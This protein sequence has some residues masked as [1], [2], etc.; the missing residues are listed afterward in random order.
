MTQAD[1]VP[2]CQPLE[3]PEPAAGMQGERWTPG[4]HTCLS[5]TGDQPYALEALG[6]G[7]SATSP[8]G[9]GSIGLG[10]LELFCKACWGCGRGSGKHSGHSGQP[11]YPH[12][13]LGLVM[14]RD[15]HPRIGLSPPPTLMENRGPTLQTHLAP[16]RQRQ[17]PLD[18]LTKTG[19][20]SLQPPGWRVPYGTQVF[21][22]R[23]VSMGPLGCG[24][25]HRGQ[26]FPP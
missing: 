17:P 8:S 19:G 14:V 11:M 12:Q 18:F 2:A 6:V 24:G 3:H 1:R 26:G 21:R 13:G 22:Q 16:S 23:P 10:C 4:R 5:L 25:S 7:H 20:P 15:P 9:G